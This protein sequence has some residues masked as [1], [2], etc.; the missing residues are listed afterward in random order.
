[1]CGIA[2]LEGQVSSR[3]RDCDS[4][5]N[6]DGLTFQRWNRGQALEKV[7]NLLGAS[8]HDTRD[9]TFRFDIGAGSSACAECLANCRRA[10]GPGSLD[11]KRAHH[12]VIA[13]GSRRSRLCRSCAVVRG[14]RLHGAQCRREL[15][16]TE[17][18]DLQDRR[19]LGESRGLIAALDIDTCRFW[20]GRCGYGHKYTRSAEGAHAFCSGLDH[21]RFFDL[22]AFHFESV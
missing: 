21:R 9:W 19:K 7:V 2:A 3:V 8:A 1:M 14:E 15:Q 20:R 12:S 16:F 18:N 22:H 17:A 5:A 11:G 4:L 10:H 6:A 13:S